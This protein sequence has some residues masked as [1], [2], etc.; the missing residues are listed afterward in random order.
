MHEHTI[1]IPLEQIEL[2][3]QYYPR[4]EL[5]EARILEF[6]EL[7]RDPDSAG[8]LPPVEL[9]PYPTQPG[10]FLVAEGWHRTH[11]HSTSAGG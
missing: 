4:A 3:W 5:D 8:L 7:L 1:D 2:D 6:R 10:R 11:A 9:V